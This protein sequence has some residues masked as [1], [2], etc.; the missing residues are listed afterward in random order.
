MTKGHNP[1]MM[2]GLPNAMPPQPVDLS[3]FP[4]R[5]VRQP[6]AFR[7]WPRFLAVAMLS[8]LMGNVAFAATRTASLLV[9]V[10]VLAGCQVS[11]AL[12][13]AERPASAANGLSAPVSVNCSLPVSYQV[14]VDSL[15]T[16]ELASLGSTGPDLA[17]LRG[18]ANPYELDS[19]RALDE[20]IHATGE[21]EYLLAELAPSGLPVVS[22]D[23]DYRPADGPEPET[24]TVT[25]VY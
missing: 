4:A 10:S 8:G 3:Y 25:I 12:Y 13:S 15:P 2:S 6:L 9:S 16:T 22:G 11:P 19:L 21:P 17:G 7:V 20:S 5:V 1:V 24:I 14:S 23:G 18:Y